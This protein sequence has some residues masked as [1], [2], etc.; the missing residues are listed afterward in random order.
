MHAAVHDAFVALTDRQSIAG[1][2]DV[3]GVQVDVGSGGKGHGRGPVCGERT[4]DVAAL[5]TVSH[6]EW[7]LQE[8]VGPDGQLIPS[9][10][11]EGVL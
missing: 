3:G 5:N 9:W 11:L 4:R 2:V 10:L 6:I 7:G 8:D 1:E